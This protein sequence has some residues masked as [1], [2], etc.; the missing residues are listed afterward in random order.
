MKNHSV[1]LHI[2][3][4]V[5]PIANPPRSVPYHLKE[6]ASKIM[7]DIIKQ[8]IEEYPINEPA[9][10]VSNAVIAPKPELKTE[11]SEPLSDMINISFNK[12][13]FRDFLKVT[14]VIPVHK[15]GEKLD[16]NN[17]RSIS[18]FNISN[19]MKKQCIPD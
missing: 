15:K 12:G 2:S 3:T 4:E 13:T 5:K 17:Y 19:N 16:S 8:N 14:N 11:I 7:E 18:L 1:K 9:S 6:R 10:W